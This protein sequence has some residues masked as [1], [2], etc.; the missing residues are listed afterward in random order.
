MK[1]FIINTG[2]DL[3]EDDIKVRIDRMKQAVSP[4]V[5]ITM[6]CL[7][8]TRICIDSQLDVA[9]AAPEIIQKA[10]SAERAGYDAVGIYCTSDPG[11]WACREAVKIPVIGAGMASFMTA[12]MLGNQISFLSTAEGRR[13]EK[14]EFARQCGI[15]MS[16]IASVRSVEYDIL[17]EQVRERRDS[18][19]Q[20]GESLKKRLKESIIKCR[21]EDHAEVV[22]LGCLSFA[23]MGRSLSEET[24]IPVID[25]A[26]AMASS[27]EALV[28]QG[29]NHSKRTYT[30]PPERKRSWG[31]GVIEI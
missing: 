18:Q 6:E 22:I 1:L 26:Y 4:D 8:N 24:G 21:D 10:I 25:P 30:N 9:L 16:R 5:E 3:S 11:L 17:K 13:S 31:A 15:D 14:I 20:S 7:E 27:M 12:M 29:L 23:G 2:Y 28:R 19:D